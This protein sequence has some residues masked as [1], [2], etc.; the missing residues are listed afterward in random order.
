[1]SLVTQNLK[2]ENVFLGQSLVSIKEGQVPVYKPE[3]ITSSITL[4]PSQFVNSVTE[5]LLVD[6]TTSSKTITFPNA[7]DV[8]SM[9]KLK[10]Y[11][12]FLFSVTNIGS[13]PF[14]N[15]LTLVSSP[16]ISFGKNV[17]TSSISNGATLNFNCVC[18][19]NT[20][21]PKIIVNF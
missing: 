8:I 20:N 13:S 5:G 19:N 12:I 11:D 6:C 4:T 7:A 1:M 14:T 17:P 9:L 15:T 16:S 18:Y 10:K 21:S 3:V 2:I